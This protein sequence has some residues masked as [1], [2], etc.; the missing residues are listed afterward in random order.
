MEDSAR[1]CMGK[2]YAAFL[3]ERGQPV[4]IGTSGKYTE[5]EITKRDCH[6]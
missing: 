3:D 1:G 4:A 5:N 2:T 6:K